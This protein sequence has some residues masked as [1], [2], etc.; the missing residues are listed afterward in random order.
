MTAWAQHTLPSYSVTEGP[1]EDYGK[2]LQLS[3]LSS[4][5]DEDGMSSTCS[6]A[7]L[8]TMRP[9]EVLCVTAVKRATLGTM[10]MT[11]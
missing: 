8:F 1:K 11:R 10:C 3:F 7:S 2:F 6:C 5:T 9:P 4:L